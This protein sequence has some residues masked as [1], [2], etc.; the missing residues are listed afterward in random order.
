MYCSRRVYFDSHSLVVRAWPSTLQ[1]CRPCII[2]VRSAG[3]DNQVQDQDLTSHFVCIYIMRGFDRLQAYVGAQLARIHP[4]MVHHLL[5]GPGWCRWPP[6]SR[7]RNSPGFSGYRTT[8]STIVKIRSPSLPTGSSKSFSGVRRT[9][10]NKMNSAATK[11]PSV[12]PVFLQI[13]LTIL[14][15]DGYRSS[16]LPHWPG[17][18]CR[19]AQIF[20]H[21][22]RADSEPT[23]P[24]VLREPFS[25]QP[26]SLVHSHCLGVGDSGVLASSSWEGVNLESVIL[27]EGE[28]IITHHSLG[29]G[30]E[31]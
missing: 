18:F 6:S 24:L 17:H 5:F 31:V 25:R 2:R 3:P 30:G 8:I 19:A 12:S 11:P 7:S 4:L 14:L 28:E 27:S 16:Y 21:S 13:A 20:L 10:H 22:N 15:L 26:Q 23:S 1:N 29:F 9:C